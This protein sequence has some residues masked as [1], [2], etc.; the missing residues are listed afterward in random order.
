MGYSMDET[1]TNLNPQF[2]SRKS[3]YKKARVKTEDNKI[4]LISYNTEVIIIENNKPF[5]N[6]NY[7]NISNTTLR[8]IKEFLKQNGFK[9]DSKSQILADYKEDL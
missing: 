4:I 7:T 6:P 8:H 1:I 3:F 2:D 5:L 9:A